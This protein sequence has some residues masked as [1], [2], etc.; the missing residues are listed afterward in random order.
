ML[1]TSNKNY[2]IKNESIYIYTSFIVTSLYIL[3]LV[4][5]PLQ[6]FWFLQILV[7]LSLK[8]IIEPKL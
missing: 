3:S 5:I 2:I 1:E 8:Y 6:L 4:Y 7:V